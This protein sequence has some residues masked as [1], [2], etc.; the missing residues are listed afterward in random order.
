MYTEPEIIVGLDLGT[1]KIAV[2][3][4]ERDS[5]F[6]DAQIIGIGSAPSLGIRK[7]L[8][9][10]LEQAVQAVRMA[11][12]DAEKMVGF[13]IDEATVAFS[14]IDATSIT[15]RGMVSLGRVPRQ[16]GIQDIERV[17][18]AAQSEL[19]V[20]SNRVTLHTIPVKYSLDGNSGIDD[21]LGMTGIRLEIELQSVI[22][23]T[24]VIQNIINCVE[25]AGLNVNGLV[26][27]SLASALG[28]LTD[29][30][31]RTGAVSLCVG[32]G[33]T[34]VALFSDGRPVRLTVIPIGG[35][36]ITNDLAYVLKIPISKAENIKHQISLILDENDDTV[37]VEA[38]G[39]TKLLEVS[40]AVDVVS[41]RLEELF[42]DHVLKTFSDQNVHMFPAGIVL[43]GGVAK[44]GGIETFTT[45]VM[46]L[47]VRI[48]DPLDSFQM[49]PGRN[50][51][52]YTT[53][54]GIIRYIMNKERNPYR[55]I[56][57]PIEVLR[58]GGVPAF[59]AAKRGGHHKNPK[60]VNGEGFRH[61]LEMVKKSMK[62]L[63]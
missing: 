2:V 8:I 25:S 5:R 31:T 48:A 27:K 56:E 20:P 60:S 37:E 44:T 46:N 29:E 28:S 6:Q 36:H 13:E 30:E 7:G 61:F 18:E 47:P 14:G 38:R 19:S 12:Q 53:S 34:G 42:V 26:I 62:E 52:E 57:A 45:E 3:V 55:Y 15:S 58:S 11:V 63:F 40:E 4:A 50:D 59:I 51:C 23:P 1:S 35:D 16:V 17:I 41:C 54:S 21:P 10:N 43:S 33:T 49:P 32:G 39:R 24:S 22:V 9:V